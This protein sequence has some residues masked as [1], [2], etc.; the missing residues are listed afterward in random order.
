[1]EAVGDAEQAFLK[2]VELSGKQRAQLLR[3]WYNLVIEAKEDLATII[4]TENGKP[5]PEA[6]GE[7]AYASD[8]I[9]WY[10]GEATRVDGKVSDPDMDRDPV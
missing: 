7:V 5:R 3:T 10:S 4:S 6:V 9:D 2:L 8:F 1:M